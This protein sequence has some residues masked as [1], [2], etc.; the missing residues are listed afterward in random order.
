MSSYCFCKEKCWFCSFAGCRTLEYLTVVS[1]SWCCVFLSR[2]YLNWKMLSLVVDRPISSSLSASPSSYSSVR[3]FL[4]RNGFSGRASV[5]LLHCWTLFRK[6][7]IY[8]IS[9]L[10]KLAFNRQWGGREGVWMK[11]FESSIFWFGK[12]GN[13]IDLTLQ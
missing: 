9:C 12:N 8:L 5:L 2:F 7:S 3:T 10:W 13:R 1:S 6:V 4:W 11:L